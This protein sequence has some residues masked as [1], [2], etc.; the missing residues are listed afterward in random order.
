[1]EITVAQ[2]MEF[3]APLAFEHWRSTLRGPHTEGVSREGRQ[4]RYQFREVFGYHKR[5]KRPIRL[6]TGL[7]SFYSA[8]PVLALIRRT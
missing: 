8:T 4:R 7:V 3:G 2:S 1:M 5:K 6:R